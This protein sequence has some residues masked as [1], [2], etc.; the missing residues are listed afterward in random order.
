MALLD[1]GA[2]LQH[3]SAQCGSGAVELSHV[4]TASSSETLG[5]ITRCKHPIVP[6]DGSNARDADA[7]HVGMCGIDEGVALD[8]EDQLR[9]TAILS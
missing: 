3:F 9:G 4:R 7:W 1:R 5:L 8:V 2:S 6:A